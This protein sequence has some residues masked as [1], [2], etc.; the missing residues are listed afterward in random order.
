MASTPI[1]LLSGTVANYFSTPHLDAMQGCG[2]GKDAASPA[3]ELVVSYWAIRGLGAPLRM[4]AFFSEHPNVNIVCHDAGDPSDAATYKAAWFD[5]AKPDL[6]KRNAMINLPYIIDTLPCGAE[7]EEEGGCK[8]ATTLVVTQTNACIAYL[9]E[10][11]G[12]QGATVVER[13][14]VQQVLCQTMDL[15]NAAVSQFYS[16]GDQDKFD[17]SVDAYVAKLHVHLTKIETFMEQN[18]T[19]FSASDRIL[20]SD[21]HLWEMLDQNELFAQRVC[22]GC[23]SFL[24]ADRYPR[25]R[26]L[27]QAVRA[28][29]Q[30]Q[31]YFD[32]EHATL[33][34][35]NP[36]GVLR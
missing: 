18:G 32:S 16:G 35:N 15:R 23:D 7:G 34:M 19:S 30:L 10:K 4:M 28:A 13:A 3:G 21:F 12:L 33:P 22:E 27:H 1:T 5:D 31:R 25:L 26:R 8:E 14:R 24:T 20:S 2:E 36:H 9:G 11:F 29:P 6:L 17:G